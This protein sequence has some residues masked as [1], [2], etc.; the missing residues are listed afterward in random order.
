MT[1]D[2][3]ELQ[4]LGAAPGVLRATL[5][6]SVGEALRLRARERP[7]AL[8]LDDAHFAD[9]ATLDAIEYATLA[10]AEGPLWVCV[11]ARPALNHLKPTWG[12][13]SAAHLRLDLAPLGSDDCANL[14]RQLLLPVES[15]PAATLETLLAGTHGS[16]FLLTELVRGLKR[17]GIVRRDPGRAA[18][19]SPPT[20][21]RSCRTLPSPIGSRSAESA[22]CRPSWPPT[23]G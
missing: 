11:L 7:L 8:I 13:R 9:D 15:V 2:A 1:P 17:D 20:S 16:P 23:P 4:A 18:G 5:S 14:A 12:G 21:S 6:R 3:P 19:S 22:L 10:E